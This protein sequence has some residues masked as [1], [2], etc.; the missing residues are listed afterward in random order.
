MLSLLTALV[1]AAAPL[2]D[3]AHV[4]L[5]ATTDV[6]GRATDWDYV[7]DRPFAGGLARVATVVDSLRARYP[8]QVVVVDAGD[9]L[10]GDPFATYFA[11]IRPVEPHP[12][13][14]AMNLAGYDAATPGSHDFDW[15]LPFLTRA[16]SEARFPYVS[17][18]LFALPG[19]TLIYPAYRVVQRQGVRIAIT[20]LTTPGTMV[21]DDEQLRGRARLAPI[22]SAAAPALEAMR[23][24]ADVAVALVHS[25][26]GDE[27]V[28]AA[29]ARLPARPDVVV[30]GHSHGEIRDSVIGGV[31]FVQPR[32]FGAS[33]SVVHLDLVR[34]AGSWRVR[35]VRA[36]LVSTAQVTA[37]PLLARRL[38]PARDSVRAWARMPVGLAAAPMPAAGAR[39]GP[40]PILDWLNDVQRRRAGADL[41]AASV[42]DLRGGFAADTIRVADVLAF[43]PFDDVLRAVRISGAQL[44]AYLEW[45]ARYFHVDPA[46]RISVNDSVPGYDDDVVAG[47][48]YDIDLRRPFGDRI[49]RLEVR[50]RAVQPSDSFTLALDSRRQTG[51]GG[52]TMLRGAPVV[53]DRG[54]RILDLLIADLR[55]RSPLDPAAV[56]PGDWRVVPEVPAMAVRALFGVAAKP[57]PPAPRDSVVLRVLA[58]S[59]LHGHLERAAALKAA[60]DSLARACACPTLRLDAGDELQGTLLSNASA[61]RATVDVLNRL[62]LDAAAV[63]NHD[64][65]WSVDTLRRRMAEARYPWLAANI[66]D[67]A[68]GARPGWAVP[69]RVLQMGGLRVGVVG[70]ITSETKSIVRADRVAGLRFGDGALALHAP[71]RELGAEHPD[72]TILLAHAGAVCDGAVCQ[73]EIM[74]LA[75]SLDPGSV[76]LIVAGHTHRLVEARAGGVPIVEAGSNGEAIAVADLVRTPAGGRVFRTRVQEIPA[77]AGPG[78]AAVAALVARYQERVDSLAARVV[79]RLK[80]PLPRSDARLGRLVAEANRNAVRAD[81]GLVNAGGIRADLPAGPVTY[82]ALFEVEPFQNALVT[83]TLTGA[84]LRETLEQAVQ[85]AGRPT[86]ELA[87][88]LVRYDPTRPPGRRIQAIRLQGGRKLSARDRYRVALPDFLARGGDGFARL[89]AIPADPSGVLDVDA[90]REFLGRLP[91]PVEVAP[92]SGF[93]STRP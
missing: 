66:A 59:D 84:E 47:A 93:V 50:G 51:A 55:A 6:H 88:A 53:Y 11:R 63:G 9:L 77:D 57:A 27:H 4:V 30:V 91:Q 26:L 89:A 68:S 64:L 31:H 3:T 78:D 86:L 12:I 52:Y 14:E 44:R 92:G 72:V 18:N 25:G 10:Q 67:S 82:G 61:G 5:V 54:E 38:A 79:A 40:A 7:A 74:R 15:G 24:D 90:L 85:G 39:A 73:G 34:E 32:P 65:D 71:L 37:S 20:G 33:V 42:F 41:S 83:L 23:R 2:Q 81:V 46:G 36:D 21:G 62:G 28:A 16:V 69:W 49:V 80:F 76:D 19:D 43:Y 35:R 70:Y 45:S 75:E 8:G 56:P 1:L 13:I 58:I 17:A 22:E 87:G 60:M 48:A 29:L